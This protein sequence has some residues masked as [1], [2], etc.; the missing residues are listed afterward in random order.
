LHE[1]KDGI[2]LPDVPLEISI[3]IDPL[4]SKRASQPG[5]TILV[6]KSILLDNPNGHHNI[7][8]RDEEAIKDQ[9]EGVFK[10][11]IEGDTFAIVP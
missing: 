4:Q 3:D 2:L 11:P 6:L 5:E 10:E 8:S 7:S 9:K 1:Q